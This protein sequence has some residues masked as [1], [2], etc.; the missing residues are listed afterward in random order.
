MSL[1][2]GG[3]SWLHYSFACMQFQSFR[4]QN[5]LFVIEDYATPVVCVGFDVRP[6]C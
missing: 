4:V 5:V 6:A 3:F 1:V 2:F